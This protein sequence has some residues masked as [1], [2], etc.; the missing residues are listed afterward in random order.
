MEERKPLKEIFEDMLPIHIDDKG[1]FPHPGM[2]KS[3]GSDGLS[4]LALA[5]DPEE[6]IQTMLTGKIL[7]KWEEFIFGIDRTTS[8]HAH[9]VP[10]HWKNV[11]TIV[12]Y[13]EDKG[14]SYGVFAY[15]TKDDHDDKIVWDNHA[16]NAVIERELMQVAANLGEKARKEM[17]RRNT[18]KN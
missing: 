18:Q 8:P 2:G 7:H 9:G 4:I 17:Q 13:E 14:F 6:T 3:F 5:V 10:L 1:I 16:W 11:L 15:N 12:H